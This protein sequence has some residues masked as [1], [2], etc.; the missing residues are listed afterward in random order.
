MNSLALLL[1]ATAATGADPQPVVQETII[2]AGSYTYTEAA[3]DGRP[4]FLGRIRNALGS[5]PAPTP[6]YPAGA[7]TPVPLAPDGSSAE[8]PL[9][10][11]VPVLTPAPPAT[12]RPAT[13][14]AVVTQP[15]YTY[16]APSMTPAPEP[17]S[18]T[19]FPRLHKLFGGSSS[20]SSQ[21]PQALP[22]GMIVTTPRAVAPAA[23]PP[24][25][26]AAP[27]PQGQPQRMPI[28]NP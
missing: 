10:D 6:T 28:G 4:G 27:V 13:L 12:V 18:R 15:A 26:A 14:P 7:T 25:P 22:E 11:T 2:P 24:A 5:K 1:M 17:N 23:P 21:S 9:A 8:P 20:Q 16:P 3:P 19:R